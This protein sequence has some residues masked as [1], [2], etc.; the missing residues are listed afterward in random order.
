MTHLY[1]T[2]YYDQYIKLIQRNKRS[3]NEY[4]HKLTSYLK[5]QYKIK[6]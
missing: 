5:S 2:S 4:E 3:R 6:K 1:D